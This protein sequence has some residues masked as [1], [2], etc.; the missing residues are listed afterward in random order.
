M[1]HIGDNACHK[2]TH[3]CFCV[4][5]FLYQL[6]CVAVLKFT[7]NCKRRIHQLFQHT[8]KFPDFHEYLLSVSVYI[9]I[10]SFHNYSEIV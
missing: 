10:P 8:A 2:K 4:L 5:P 3:F 9:I 6:S 7:D 1:L